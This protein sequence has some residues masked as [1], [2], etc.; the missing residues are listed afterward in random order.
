MLVGFRDPYGIKPLAL[1]TRQNAKTAPDWMMV[2]ESAALTQLD[3][4]Y[5]S[6]VQ[7]GK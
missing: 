1:G 4:S 6:D 5:L 2:S 3:F 7:P